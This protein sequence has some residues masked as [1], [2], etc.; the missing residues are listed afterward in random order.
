LPE[1]IIHSPHLLGLEVTTHD[2]AW[3]QITVTE[4]ND[5]EVTLL[6]LPPPGFPSKCL[7]LQVEP[8]ESGEEVHLIVGGNSKPFQTGFSD[9]GWQL[10]H[11]EVDGSPYRE[12]FRVK[13]CVNVRNQDEAVDIVRR[14]CGEACLHDAPIVLRVEDAPNK[15]KHVNDFLQAVSQ[16]ESVF[17]G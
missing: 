13:S 8:I 4:T 14:L 11:V 12:Y 17:R 5:S 1:I 7:V 9:L 2:K 15:D 16:I 10:K 3:C 6:D